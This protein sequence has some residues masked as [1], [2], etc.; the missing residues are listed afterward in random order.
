MFTPQSYFKQYRKCK[1]AEEIEALATQLYKEV[2]IGRSGKPLAPK[3]VANKLSPFNKLINKIPSKTLKDGVN[4]YFDSQEKGEIL[5]P[6][7]FKF[8]TNQIDF[9][10]MNL[11][12]QAQRNRKVKGLERKEIDPK[13]YMD[14]AY[15]L[16]ESDDDYSVFIGVQAVTGRRLIEVAD[17]GEFSQVRRR[18]EPCS[19]PDY[20][21]R[22]AGQ[23]K[24]RDY[25]DKSDPYLIP[26]LLPGWYVYRKLKQLESSELGQR[27]AEKRQELEGQ[28]LDEA[29]VRDRLTRGI[30]TTLN[31]RVKE[32]FDG[33][34]PRRQGKAEIST[35]DLRAAYLAI[36]LYRDCP[37]NKLGQ[38]VQE[39]VTFIGAIA[40]HFE[41][42]GKDEE[43]MPIVKF[44][45]SATYSYRDYE[46]LSEPTF[47]QIEIPKMRS[48]RANEAAAIYI[49]QVKQDLG[50]TSQ[51]AAIDEVVKRSQELAIAK[52]RI[53]ELEQQVSDKQARADGKRPGRT[54]K[55]YQKGLDGLQAIMDYNDAQESDSLRWEIT[56]R[57]VQGTGV[58]QKIA[59]QVM[60][61]KAQAIKDH[62][63][64]WGFGFQHNNRNH[65][66][67]KIGNF[68]ST[69][70]E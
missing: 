16:M 31:D 2:S 63:D 43:G 35:H 9:E 65:S 39:P 5:R 70:S 15:Q 60:K 69:V 6:L 66:G 17:L 48:L 12:Q 10:S 38:F 55:A 25:E 45:E 18:T 11:K 29:E 30:Q 3:S 40:G 32:H 53:A 41:E 36:A 57:A 47:Y 20:C 1:T 44:D 56:M 37:R 8:T 62:N 34:L 24:K 7:H 28:G 26:T 14:K 27:L 13:A 23:A 58:S 61:D 51:H 4:A 59:Q 54:A 67:Q 21:M 52:Q 19:K 42:V 50:L 46:L 49:E 68:V 33:I 22:F 64:K